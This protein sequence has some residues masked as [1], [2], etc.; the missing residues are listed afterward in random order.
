LSL[1]VLYATWLHT[2]SSNAISSNIENGSDWTWWGQTKEKSGYLPSMKRLTMKIPSMK[3]LFVSM[4]WFSIKWSIRSKWLSMKW[5]VAELII[6][7][8]MFLVR[9][10]NVRVKKSDRA[11][12]F[13]ILYREYLFQ[14]SIT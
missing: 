9:M 11:F 1:Q 5:S 13:F 12:Q 3:W 6:H 14:M 2:S 4:K 10:W 7:K 8:K